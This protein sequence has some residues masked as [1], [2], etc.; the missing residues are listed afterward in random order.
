M[1]PASPPTTSRRSRVDVVEDE[2]VDRQPAAA[3]GEA[4]DELGRIGA[5]AADDRDLDAHLLC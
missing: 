4:L 5:P 3:S 1:R 2:L